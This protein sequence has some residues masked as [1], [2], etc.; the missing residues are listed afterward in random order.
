[1]VV[2][3]LVIECTMLYMLD[4]EDKLDW[5]QLEEVCGFLFVR[6]LRQA[7]AAQPASS[8]PRSPYLGLPPD[9]GG[10]AGAQRS[11][12]RLNGRRAVEERAGNFS[13][14]T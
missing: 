12:R 3:N 10:A 6:A 1:M 2:F 11:R 14:P 8:A 4:N 5:D 9:A 7:Q 13:A